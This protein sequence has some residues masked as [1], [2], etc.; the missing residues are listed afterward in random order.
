M[1]TVEFRKVG[2]LLREWRERRRMS[3][4]DL[5]YEAEISQRHLSFLEIG[6]SQPSREMILRLAEH[7]E[8]PLRERNVLLASA[9]FAAVFPERSLD[10]RSLP[11]A[12]RA[13]DLI[14]KGL[15]PN[16]S[17]AVD[18]HWSLV[19]ANKAAMNVLLA[20][21][22]Q[23]LLEPPVN[24]L[25]LC[26]HPKGFTP[27]VMNYSE[28]R[29]SVL[30]YLERQVEATADALLMELLEELRSYSKPRSARNAAP[31]AETANS[32][33]S[34]PL[35][36]MKKEGEL[37]FIST[38]TVFGTPIDVT[39]S[40]LAIESFFPADKRTEEVLFSKGVKKNAGSD[41]ETF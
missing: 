12:R 36:L 18:R 5:A 15:E 23:S 13:V 24:M 9:G 6:R 21:V 7:L 35:R 20:D 17:F 41:F 11:A 37:S 32:G 31:T 39:L 26:L 27:Q 10:E 22:D 33:I 8:I 25:R 28:W 30:K 40:E 16:P 14:L 1:Q 38:V 3:Q 4:L 2:E 19:A 34:I 29:G